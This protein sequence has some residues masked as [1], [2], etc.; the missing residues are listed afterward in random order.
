MPASDTPHSDI[1]VSDTTIIIVNSHT[2]F[3]PPFLLFTILLLCNLEMSCHRQQVQHR[4]VFV[5]QVRRVARSRQLGYKSGVP[6]ST[7]SVIKKVKADCSLS[8]VC[9]DNSDIEVLCGSQT[10]ELQILLCPIY[11]NGYNESLLAL[12]SEHSKHECKGIPDWMA[13]PPV[14][15]FN[16]SIT[17]EAITACSSDLKVGD[18]NL[19]AHSWFST[20]STFLT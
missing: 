11:F 14:L 19:K 9:S 5:S 10:V 7:N 16:F 20:L 18:L 6:P 3:S 8:L 1:Q 17:E 4:F 13:D 15:K 12:N 2:F